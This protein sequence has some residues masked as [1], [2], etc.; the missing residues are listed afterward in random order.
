MSLG[1]EIAER[2]HGTADVPVFQA[3]VL[4]VSANE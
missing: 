4:G 1:G 3:V 2:R